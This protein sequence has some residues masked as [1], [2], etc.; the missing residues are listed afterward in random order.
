MNKNI[1][2]PNKA[3]TKLQQLNDVS[4]LLNMMEPPKQFKNFTNSPP[5]S[6]K[7][8]EYINLQRGTRPQKNFLKTNVTVPQK[9]KWEINFD[10]PSLS[11]KKGTPISPLPPHEIENTPRPV[12]KLGTPEPSFSTDPPRY[13]KGKI[14]FNEF[15]PSPS[16]T[17]STPVKKN[18][19][20]KIPLAGTHTLTPERI[21]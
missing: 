5:N 17:D 2:T 13:G 21:R 3:L 4:R 19:S 10:S 11:P 1:H 7:L 20:K 15:T 12:L 8:E 18:K 14:L 6:A 16:K 9:G